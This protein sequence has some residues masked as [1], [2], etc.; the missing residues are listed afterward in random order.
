MQFRTCSHGNK[1]DS[2]SRKTINSDI[3]PHV[4]HFGCAVNTN[5]TPTCTV[6]VNQFFQL[7][8][9]NTV[10]LLQ[11]VNEESFHLW[12]GLCLFSTEK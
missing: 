12:Q 2:L 5:F 8:A 6:L 10:V 7:K 1:S 3:Y 4:K 9:S 11:I